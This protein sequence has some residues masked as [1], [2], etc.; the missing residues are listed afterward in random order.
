[1]SSML[2]PNDG[3]RGIDIETPSG[4]KKKLNADRAGRVVVDDPK[5]ANALRDQG[6]TVAGS[7]SGF[8][9]RFGVWVCK[10]EKL[11]F[12]YQMKCV[13]CGI[14]KSEGFVKEQNG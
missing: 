12:D 6:F 10:C 3:V 8:K 2:V 9:S 14:D 4:Q 1:M 5:L 13:H 7:A 11:S